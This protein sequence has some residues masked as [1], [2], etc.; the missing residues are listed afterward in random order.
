MSNGNVLGS[1]QNEFQIAINPLNSQFAIGTSNDSGAAGVGIFRTTDG[2]ATWASAD[3]STYGVPGSCCDPGVDYAGDGSAVYAVILSTSG[4]GITHIIKSTENG[5]T[6]PQRTQVL[7]PDRENIAVDPSNPNIVYLTYSELTTSNRIKGYKSTDGGVTWGPTFFVGDIAPAQGYE[8]SSHPRVASNGWFYVGYQQYTN[9]TTGCSAGVQNVLARSTDGGATFNYTVVPITQGGAC[10]SSQAGRGIFCT[11]VAGTTSF[12]S[13]SHP[14]IGISPS[15][16]QHV[17]MLYSGGE[18][19][20][21]YTCASSTGFHSDTLFRSST[22]GGVTFSAPA[23]I[24]TDAAGKDQ[25]FPWM[26]VKENGQIWVGWND[27]RDDP[28]NVLSR[29]Y[30]SYSNDEGATWRKLDGSLGNDPV[31]DVQT[32]PSTF[33]GDYH[34]LAARGN[35][36]L[37][38]WYDFAHQCR[39]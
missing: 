21:A 37:G 25:Y 24:N 17:Y 3:A 28:N 9:S 19:E 11:N 1:N 38:M 30:Q 10:S 34:G 13:R 23:K 31:A 26:D 16:P 12:R 14:I 33:I 39:R 6:W 15:N 2:G 20:T 5:A 4:G 32:Q 27:R 36:V 22:D 29:W 7:T 18:L 35:T 8:Q